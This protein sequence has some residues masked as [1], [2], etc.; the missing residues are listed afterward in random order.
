M[1]ICCGRMVISLLSCCP[2]SAFAGRDN[3]SAMVLVFPGMYSS[4]KSY[5]WRSACHLA[6]HRFK[7]LGDFQYCRFAWSVLMT[8]GVF[9]HPRYGLQCAR[10]FM[11]VS[12]SHLYML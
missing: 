6:V 7:F 4:W 11:M 10:A 9:V 3:A 12:S 1:Q 8:N 2:W 5:S